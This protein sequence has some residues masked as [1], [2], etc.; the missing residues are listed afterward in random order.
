MNS[1]IVLASLLVIVFSCKNNPST[2]ETDEFTISEKIA[3][4]SGIDHWGNVNSIQFT[5]NVDRADS[6]FERSWKWNPKTDDVI[7]MTKTDTV[8]YNRSTLDSIS[9]RADKGFIN[10]K[11]WLLAPFN[12]VWDKGT[13]ITYEDSVKVNLSDNILN[14]ATTV[15]GS[16]G[17]Y[18]PGDAY[19]FYYDDNYMVREW[20]FRKGNQE[21]PSMITTW[22]DYED[23]NGIK[24]AR[25]H[26]GKDNSVK[27]YFTN[28]KVE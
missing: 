24:I 2:I 1:K 7:M 17:G 8:S 6:H 18:T 22:E 21:E 11:F 10:D 3:K 27:L 16:E 15:Y 13:T 26:M 20:V 12:L 14:K 4:A 25:T 5:F 28:I 9:T 19:D 23:F